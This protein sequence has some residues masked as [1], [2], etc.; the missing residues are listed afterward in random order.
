MLI[1][2]RLRMLTKLG[3]KRGVTALMLI[4][5]IVLSFVLLTVLGVSIYAF[6]LADSL[7]Q[8]VDFELGN[9]S[10]NETY[11]QSLGQG[12]TAM[13]TT[14]PQIVSLGV[15]LGMVIVMCIIGYVS[16]KIGRLWILFDFFVIVVAEVFAVLISE[17]FR[18]FINSSQEFLTIYSTTLS[19][20]ATFVL[21]LPISLPIIG[22]LIMLVT[23]SLNRN[24][25]QP[26]GGGF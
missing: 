26:V 22:G 8:E 1:K 25:N 11:N 7:F 19:A 3:N 2:K 18:E 5:I 9:I 16:P 15:L 20:S 21:T 6:S 12:I 14:F 10:Y 13:R 24:F 17:S 23:Y 4:P